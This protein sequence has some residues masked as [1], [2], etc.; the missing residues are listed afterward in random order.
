MTTKSQVSI[1]CSRS[2]AI[3]DLVDKYTCDAWMLCSLRPCGNG[4]TAFPVHAED[5]YEVAGRTQ[6]S[7]SG[8]GWCARPCY[9]DEHCPCGHVPESG[10]AQPFA[11]HE[12]WDTDRWRPRACDEDTSENV[13]SLQSQI[14]CDVFQAHGCPG[15]DP[16]LSEPW[17]DTMSSQRQL[18]NAQ[19]VQ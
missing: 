8:G 4:E 11:G 3:S 14:A 1:P 7:A 18:P 9:V 13:G 10:A 12:V 19:L 15:L 2:S 5:S 6:G 17:L 16:L